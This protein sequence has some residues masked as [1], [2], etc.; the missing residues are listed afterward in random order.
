MFFINIK[1][2]ILAKNIIMRFR[3]ILSV[4]KKAFGNLL[5]INYQYEQSAAIYR[6]LSRANSEFSAWLHD[7]GFVNKEGNKR[8]KLFTYSRFKIEQWPL[9]K[10]SERLAILSARVEWQISFLPEKITETFIEGIFS[11]QTFEVGD[12]RSTLKFHV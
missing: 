6:I 8:F 1:V 9:L 10:D 5:P 3:L 2:Y 7:N 11:K 4:N 12:R